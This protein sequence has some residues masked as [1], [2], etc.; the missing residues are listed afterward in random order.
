MCEAWEAVLVGIERVDVMAVENVLDLLAGCI[1]VTGII[2]GNT[3]KLVLKL[4][5]NG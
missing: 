4:K 5:L 3:E 2:S 1:V